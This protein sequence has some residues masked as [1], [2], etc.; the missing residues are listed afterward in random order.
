VL[1]AYDNNVPI[2]AVHYSPSGLL[3]A[4]LAEGSAEVALWDVGTGNR[5]QVLQGHAG[6]APVR[7]IAF[8]P[9]GLLLA[10]AGGSGWARAWRVGRWN[11]IARRL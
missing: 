7:A 6:A 10:T 11:R 2:R 4:S 5:L 1:R 9:G 3:L 8:S